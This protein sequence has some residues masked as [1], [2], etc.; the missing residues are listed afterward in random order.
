MDDDA[1]AMAAA[2][3]GAGLVQP[4]SEMLAAAIS[5]KELEAVLAGF[6]PEPP[7]LWLLKR[8]FAASDMDPDTGASHHR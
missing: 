2:V 8:R 1:A 4:P 7:R 6:A 3:A 5:S